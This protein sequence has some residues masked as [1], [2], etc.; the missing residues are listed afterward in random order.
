MAR[1]RGANKLGKGFII[2]TDIYW[3]FGL[4]LTVIFG[5]L[6]LYFIPWATAPFIEVEGMH[7]SNAVAE[8][9]RPVKFVVPI[10]LALITIIGVI[11]T[12]SS[13]AKSKRQN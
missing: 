12:M 4:I 2:L 3:P 9:V 6:T 1:Y 13:Y 5:G 7:L 8:L 10:L 11:R